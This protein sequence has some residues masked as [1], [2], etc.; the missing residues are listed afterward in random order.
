MTFD[1][2]LLREQLD[3][4]QRASESLRTAVDAVTALDRDRLASMTTAARELQ[5][6]YSAAMQAVKG[7]TGWRDSLTE[8]AREM[9]R[10]WRD[11]ITPLSTAVSEPAWGSIPKRDVPNPWADAIKSL[12][13]L[14]AVPTDGLTLPKFTTDALG[15]GALKSLDFA[16]EYAPAIRALDNNLSTG[17]WAPTA[18][19]IARLRPTFEQWQR[20]LEAAE[21][22]EAERLTFRQR[23]QAIA[24]AFV[25]TDFHAATRRER[26]KRLTRLIL[27]V[28]WMVNTVVQ[29]ADSAAMRRDLDTLKEQQKRQAGIIGE[30]VAQV[31]ALQERQSGI[32][33]TGPLCRVAKSAVLRLGPS[34]A[35]QRVA[36]LKVGTVLRFLTKHQR[37]YFVE[38]LNA[39][40]STS[41]VRGWVY[42][43]NVRIVGFDD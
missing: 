4:W 7:A 13:L 38:V 28:C 8:E 30:L 21:D 14:G 11:M 39:D 36:S 32:P 3:Q 37:W 22:D 34:G 2:R 9:T 17:R 16:S 1:P 10:R 42:R 29:T 18:E 5:G 25:G 24:E 15:L 20:D 19:E 12:S 33:P 27:F 43:R 41:G 6:Q 40:G 35:T 23:L 31:Q 26:I